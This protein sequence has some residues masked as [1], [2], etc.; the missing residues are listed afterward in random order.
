MNSLVS[1]H[2]NQVP[3]ARHR[4]RQQR[5]P[6]IHQPCSVSAHPRLKTVCAASGAADLGPLNQQGLNQPL[7][8]QGEGLK[9]PA[10]TDEADW[11]V[12]TL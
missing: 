10:P 2:C 1:S 5:C 6:T 8:P 3:V 7:E 12:I 11:C 4:H 9:P